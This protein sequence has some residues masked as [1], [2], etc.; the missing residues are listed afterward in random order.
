[1]RQCKWTLLILKAKVNQVLPFLQPVE[2]IY[3]CRI[4]FTRLEAKETRTI[5][6]EEEE[7]KER[8]M[9]RR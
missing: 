4:L 9:L 8:W 5:K 7:V 1:M 6:E 2:D 3:V